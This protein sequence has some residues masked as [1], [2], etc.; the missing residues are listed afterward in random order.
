[1]AS[2]TTVPEAE[3]VAFH[4]KSFLEGQT[5]M[6]LPHQF[7]KLFIIIYER[8]GRAS[9]GAGGYPVWPLFFVLILC[10]TAHEDGK[11]GDTANRPVVREG[12]P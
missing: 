1:M 5:G 7:H 12:L 2:T 8:A 10:Y 9:Q 4:G 3:I 6:S 11:A